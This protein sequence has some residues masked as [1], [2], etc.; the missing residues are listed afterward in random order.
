MALL[1]PLLPTQQ[2]A[3]EFHDGISRFHPIQWRRISLTCYAGVQVAKSMLTN[4]RHEAFSVLVASGMTAKDAYTRAGFMGKGAA[5]S[6]SRLA[7]TPAV[8]NRIAELGR[9]TSDALGIVATTRAIVDREWILDIVRRNAVAAFEERNRTAVNRAAEL[10]ARLLGMFPDP[11]EAGSEWD[12]DLEKLTEEQLLTLL[13]SMNRML[14]RAP[15]DR[16]LD[17]GGPVIELKG[18]VA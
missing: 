2:S 13:A 18:E 12:G 8:A 15:D 9:R 7:K 10:L 5:Q 6:A 3:D 1:P 11:R 16:S 17:E 14:G 4:P